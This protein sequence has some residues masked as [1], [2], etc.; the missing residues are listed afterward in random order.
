MKSKVRGVIE[1]RSHMRIS[2]SGLVPLAHG[3]KLN[4][5]IATDTPV[6]YIV[7]LRLDKLFAYRGDMVYIEKTL[8][9]VTLMLD[10][11]GRETGEHPFRAEN[12]RQPI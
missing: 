6:D 4:G 10:Y 2:S 11:T 1:D 12:P 7:E 8:Q 5:I 3:G 9:M